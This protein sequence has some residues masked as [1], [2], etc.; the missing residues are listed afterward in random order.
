MR[1]KPDMKD[2]RIRKMN[3]YG[4]PA[5]IYALSF[6]YYL[7]YYNVGISL[8]DEGYFVASTMRILNGQVPFRDFLYYPPG[9]NY[10]VAGLF[11]VFGPDLI[12]ERLFWVAVISGSVTL[13][14]VLSRRLMPFPFFAFPTLLALIVPGP[15]HKSLLPFFYL[16]SVYGALAYMDRKSVARAA[17]MGVMAGAVIYFRYDLSVFILAGTTCA[18]F[19]A[20]FLADGRPKKQCAYETSAILAGYMITIL[21][22]ALFMLSPDGGRDAIGYILYLTFKQQGGGMMA[23]PFPS[24]SL[25]PSCAGLRKFLEALFFYV[26]PAVIFSAFAYTSYRWK[27]GRLV[28]DDLIIFLMALLGACAYN[29]VVVR[30]DWPHLLQAV[31]LPYIIGSCLAWRVYKTSAAGQNPAGR[32]LAKGSVAA[33]TLVSL[34]FIT[35]N[36]NK[37]NLYTGAIGVLGQKE[38]RLNIPGAGLYVTKEEAGNLEAMTAYIDSKTSPGEPIQVFP[39]SPMLYFL[40][41]RKNPMYFDAIFPGT[42]SGDGEVRSFINGLDNKDIRLIVFQDISFTDRRDSAFKSYADPVYKY[43][44]NNYAR[45]RGFGPYD[46]YIKKPFNNPAA[47]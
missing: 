28:T 15:W 36:V 25:S 3:K 29:Q 22:A 30:A 42:F 45:D 6:C 2:A 43:I 12:L 16:L 9:A 18:V 37:V 39:Y 19:A 34:L 5:A 46:I 11:K 21:P 35:H 31:Q 17:L 10:M 27:K 26:P 32:L 1:K 7:T 23:L 24:L 47:R 20:N 13:T 44:I 4:L 33:L 38:E 8:S 41:G 40:A 14:F